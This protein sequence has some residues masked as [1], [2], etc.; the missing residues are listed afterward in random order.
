M[1]RF[2]P[3]Q[4]DLD[5][6]KNEAKALHRAH[7][8]REPEVC[9]VLRHLHRFGDATDEEILA[10]D[11]LL[12]EVQFALA[13]DY[14]FGS[15]QHLRQA[16]MGLKPPDGYQ[17]DAEDGAVILPDPPAGDGGRN[18]FASAFSMAMSYLGAS[19]DL[20]TVV[21]DTGLAFILQADALH[22][23]HGANMKNLDIGYWPLGAWGA[24]RRFDFLGRA[25]GIPLNPLPFFKDEYTA[26]PAG[27]YR[28]HHEAAI[29]ASLRAGRPVVAVAQD[30]YVVFGL[31]GG[32][33]PLLGQMSCQTE[34][35]LHRLEQF[36]WNVILLGEPGEPMDRRHADAEALDY[37]VRLGRDEVDLS[38][39]P[40]KSSGRRSWELWA[41][42]LAD[43]ELCGPHFYHANVLGH[44]KQ[45]RAAAAEYLQTMGRRHPSPV[46]AA[47]DAAASTYGKI[48]ERLSQADCG[49]EM[50]ARQR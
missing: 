33:P 9:P 31:D 25:H 23:P 28:K 45:N 8:N 24:T 47:L 2:L 50:L 39:L 1:V 46:Q 36:P 13:M 27:H 26:D 7:K 17:A 4:A 43:E 34:A 30:T 15:W 10:A 16:A 20:T 18:R 38:D 49:K 22:H 44:L 12:T 11:V 48:L 6:L 40:G 21:G 3:P 29:A 14:G 41:E 37:A 42:Q 32:N 35:N 5:H 19:A